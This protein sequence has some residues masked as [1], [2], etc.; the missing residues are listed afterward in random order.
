MITKRYAVVLA[1]GKGTRMKSSRHKVLH[2]I[3]GKSMIEHILD[4]L[5]AVKVD[6]TFIV[7]SEHGEEVIERVKGRATPVLQTEQLGTAHALLMAESHL[8]Q[9]GGVTLVL[10]G[11]TPFVTKETI[12]GLL[13]RHEDLAAHATLL[14]TE[15]ENPYGYGRVI[16]NEMGEVE[17]IV[18]EKEA[19]GEERKI[20]EVNVGFYAFDTSVIFPLLHRIGNENE[21]G[22]YYLTDLFS[23]L[24]KEGKRILSYHTDD[25][26]ET[27]SI[28]DRVALS[29]AE[30]S[31]R[32]RINEK[33]MREGVTMEDPDR[34]YIE[35]DVRIGRDTVL[36]AGT[37]LKGN[38]VIGEGCLIGPDA[39]IT[40][41]AI[42]SGVTIQHSIIVESRV[43]AHATVGPFA[44]LRPHSEIGE[45][46]KVGDFVEIK[47]SSVG[48]G[49]KIPHLAYVGDAKI[50]SH[51]NMSCGIIT[52][53][54]DGVAKH[55]T[56]VEDD[57]FIGCNVNLIAPVTVGK[58]AYVAAGSTITDPVPP[59]AL[60]I[61]RERQINKE[62]Y[63]A[64]LRARKGK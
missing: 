58:G 62:G 37:R 50:G 18:E 4:V 40:D 27:I 22:E 16:T 49:T 10:N 33:W 3:G 42:G 24:R 5:E 52:V 48:E 57:S 9:K 44:Y 14:S 51:V 28:N 1:A 35:A 32:R 6:E 19:T 12:E 64:K 39:D 11:D 61:A 25:R 55:Q 20:R 30:K 8:S 31:Y 45:R 41:S 36:Y 17:R 46:V 23:L 56:V 15:L 63:V 13:R 21:K 29:R 59:E 2:T 7:V 26:D 53:N 60:A 34:T 43:A 54:Y 47:N 38:T